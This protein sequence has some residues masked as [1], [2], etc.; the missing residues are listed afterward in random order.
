MQDSHNQVLTITTGWLAFIDITFALMPITIIYNLQLNWRKK[1]GLSCLM[2]MGVFAF[3]C[4]VV[5]TSKLPE[6]KARADITYITVSLWIWNAN[7]ANLVII[8]ACIPTLR[9]LF[10]LL[11]RHP[12]SETYKGRTYSHWK[13][14]RTKLSSVSAP[15]GISDGST[16]TAVGPGESNDGWLELGPEQRGNG[17]QQTIELDITSYKKP[18]NL[19]I[20]SMPRQTVQGSVL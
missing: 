8:A 10:L 17:I 6:L 14:G 9:P 16:T 19:D 13:E 3:V 18:K 7:E 1:V 15:I 12:E 2:G 4:A 5:K 20:E 11:F